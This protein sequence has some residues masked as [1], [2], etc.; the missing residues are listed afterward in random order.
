MNQNVLR[1]NAWVWTR[2][3]TLATA[4]TAAIALPSIAQ[5]DNA[6][7]TNVASDFP[8][9]FDPYPTTAA[10]RFEVTVASG[11]TVQYST[12]GPE[13]GEPVLYI[14]GGLSTAED[15]DAF[16]AYKTAIDTLGI[17]FILPE[18]TGY[19]ET[20]YDSSMTAAS[21]A[22]DWNDLLTALGY[23]EVKVVAAAGG[24]VYA[25]TFSTLYASRVEQLQL[26]SAL[27]ASQT[28]ALCPITSPTQYLGAQ[29]FLIDF[30]SFF[31]FLLSPPDLSVYASVPGL[32]EWQFQRLADAGDPVNHSDIGASHDFYLW[33]N[34]P[35]TDYSAA[36][37]PTFIY[38]GALDNIVP[39]S[40][41]QINASSY[42]NVAAFRTYPNG[43]SYVTMRHL[44]Q[45]LL[46]MTGRSE[47]RIICHNGKNTVVNAHAEAAH[48]AHGDTQDICA[49]VGTPAMNQ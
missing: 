37:F 21:Y 9:T 3:A 32:L 41:A 44:G 18:R 15:V 31:T 48:L 17:R 10:P 20:P 19:G 12:F 34:S 35:V 38:H 7:E 28:F 23:G 4:M 26:L 2:A 46:D 1:K 27:S 33:C 8:A 25:A 11:R 5:A 30:P 14:S 43:A 29:Q 36:T 6:H 47:K 39:I 42:P 45:V 13:D 49:W 22:A 24:G 40:H 16:A